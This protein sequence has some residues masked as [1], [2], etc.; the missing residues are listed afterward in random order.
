MEK[1][2]YTESPPMPQFVK[3]KVEQQQQEVAM[4]SELKTWGIE[5]RDRDWKAIAVH[6]IENI[7]AGLQHLLIRATSTEIINPAGWLSRRNPRKH[8]RFLLSIATKFDIADNAESPQTETIELP[9]KSAVATGKGSIKECGEAAAAMPG[10]YCV[11]Y[12]GES[13]D[14]VHKLL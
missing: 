7:K 1:E 13:Y 9:V 10:V 2:I 8:R 11:G 14:R 3:D 12:R 5:Y 6:G 4:R